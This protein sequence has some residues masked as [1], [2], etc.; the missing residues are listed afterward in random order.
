[1]SKNVKILILN[2]GSSSIKYQVINMPSE[3]LVC[4]GIIERIGQESSIIEYESEKAKFKTSESIPDHKI[5]LH[6]IVDKLL[7]P[8][9]G[10][11]KRTEEIDIVGHRV[12][13][14]GNSFSD[15]SI[16]TDQVKQQIEQYASL[17]PL[18][19]P[20]NLSGINLAEELFP[21]SKQVAVFDTAFHQTIPT[22]AKKYAIPNELY[23]KHGI[24][25][26]G[27]HGTS[28]KYVSEQAIK[29]LKLKSSKIISVHLGNGCSMTAVVN[30][31]SVDHS[32][33]F[34]PTNGL[35]MG[36]R[37]G[38]IDHSIIFYLTETLGYKSKEVN[39]LLINKSG[40]LGLT[41]HSDLRDIQAGAIAGK[42]DCILALQ[43]NAYRIRKYIGSYIA[44]MNGVD[45]IVF[46][47]G[48]GENSSVL[49]KLVLE[50]MAFFGIHM[51]EN[52]NKLNTGKIQE[53]DASL[54]KVALLVVPTN[55][56]LEIA[57]QA[58]LKFEK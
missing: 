35:I 47:G 23:E 17:A 51:D 20:H 34:A 29:Y 22:K 32:F 24:Q 5:G 41:G 56:E 36:T 13:H 1:M 39:D 14:G 52:K 2:S 10:I 16:I 18:H 6:K 40:M 30:G 27:F 25:V 31:K 55:E 53:I 49:R 43:M 42:E 9:Y 12:V 26:Y 21:L 11:I 58:F 8:D 44:A 46:T 3:Q 33:G 19:N 7:D 4:K 38:D 48:I 37:S 50:D 45:A 28:H 15:T 57:R 54:S